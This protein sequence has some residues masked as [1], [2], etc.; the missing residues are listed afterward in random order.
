MAGLIGDAIYTTPGGQTYNTETGLPYDFSTVYNQ[1]TPTPTPSPTPSGNLNTS[2]QSAYDRLR[3]LFQAYGLPTANDILDVLK[4]SAIDGDGDDI[5]QLKLQDTGSW[6]QRFKGN[7]LR[8]AAGQ[9]VLSV[10]EYLSQENQYTAVL[11]NAGL[12]VGFYDDHD[13]FSN[14]IGGGVSVAELQDRV[15]IAGDIVNREDPS[16]LDQ[17]A[18]R[19]ISKSLLLAH[20]LDP[21]RAAP[22]VKREQN[23]I[24]IGAA[25]QR[26]GL[27]ASVGQA[28]RLAE[29]GIGEAQAQQGFGQIND[30][31]DTTRKQGEIYGEDY[32]LD[33]ALGEVFEGQSDRKRKRLSGTER[34]NFGG[35]DGFGVQRRDTSGAY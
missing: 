1:P 5:V 28:D 26:S 11:R 16:I 4:Q 29:R 20:T 2:Q 22:L 32:G 35:S 33:D 24:L 8:K 17:L 9:N 7:E 23:S 25:A 12:P 27:N 18:Q 3:A 19:G 21:E 6:K 30:F 15:N 31:L 13:D 10:A 34:A 14:L